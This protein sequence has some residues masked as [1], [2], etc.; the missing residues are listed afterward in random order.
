MEF[1]KEKYNTI[2]DK[3]N[4]FIGY[5]IEKKKLYV[6]AKYHQYL[7]TFFISIEDLVAITTKGHLEQVF[8]ILKDMNESLSIVTPSVSYSR[9]IINAITEDIQELKNKTVNNKMIKEV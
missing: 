8:F 1:I 4:S 6:Y 2:Y 7:S 3:K 9:D 5:Y